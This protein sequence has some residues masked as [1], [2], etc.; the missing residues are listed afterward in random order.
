MAEAEKNKDI[1]RIDEVKTE[2]E[3][4]QTKEKLEFPKSKI[5]TIEP[6]INKSPEYL[7]PVDEIEDVDKI[8]K[9]KQ[10]FFKVEDKGKIEMEK[11]IEQYNQQIDLIEKLK[12]K[13][14]K[15]KKANDWQHLILTG[16]DKRNL[17]DVIVFYAPIDVYEFLRDDIKWK[18]ADMYLTKLL[19][20]EI[21]KY[22]PYIKDMKKGEF[23]N[24]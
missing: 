12:T 8:L 2:S 5:E 1:E 3:K 6:D 15:L 16:D 19:R 13:I 22:G 10:T 23:D 7:M 24:T 20:K 11:L 14:R 21:E 9:N 18:D 4:I 17:W